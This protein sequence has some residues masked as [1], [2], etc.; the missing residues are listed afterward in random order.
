VRIALVNDMALAVEALRRTLL[1]TPEHTVAWIARD[2]AEAVQKCAAD[3]PD[4]LLMDLLMPVMDGAEA[5]RRIMK[6]SPC[7]ILV[8]TATVEGNIGLVFEAMSFGALDAVNTPVLGQPEGEAQLLDKIALIGKLLG[9]PVPPH[10]VVVPRSSTGKVPFIVALGASTGGPQA[11]SEILAGLPRDMDA[12]IVIIQ[13]VD[14]LF[15]SGLAQWLSMRA[16]RNVELAVDGMRLDQLGGEI[17]LAGTNDHLSLRED[18]NLYYTPDPLECPY[19][20]S[21]DVFFKSLAA[22]CPGAGVAALLTGMGRDGAQGLLALR[23]AGWHTLAQ[24]EASCVLYGMPKAAAEIH[25]ATQILPLGEMAS[26][27]TA[28][29]HT[30]RTG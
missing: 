15:A 23:Q 30:R 4:L 24:D 7:A 18:L 5:T 2:G 21:V 11:L 1:K 16:G 6:Q 3:T 29:W 27:L 14:R 20:P 13:H 26:A 28:C 8:V 17:V 22:H 10:T 19:R 12:P 9:K 25:A